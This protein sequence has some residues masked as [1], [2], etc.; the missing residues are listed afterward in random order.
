MAELL[1]NISSF[2]LIEAFAMGDL[3]FVEFDLFVG[4]LQFLFY[5][6][7]INLGKFYAFPAISHVQNLL[8]PIDFL[9]QHSIFL[10]KFLDKGF[11]ESM[12]RYCL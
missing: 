2:M 9:L 1:V 7:A 8:D 5:H 11:S 3:G 10:L 4:V 12:S 6:I